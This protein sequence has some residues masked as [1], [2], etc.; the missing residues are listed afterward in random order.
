MITPLDDLKVYLKI[1]SLVTDD[2]VFL[3]GLCETADAKI[4][5]F[6]GGSIEKTTKTFTF[7]NRYA[8]SEK[9]LPYQKVNSISLFSYSETAI[10]SLVTIDTTEYTLLENP[11]RLYLNNGYAENYRYVVVVD[12]G[13]LATEMPKDIIQAGI[14]IATVMYKESDYRQSGGDGRLGIKTISISAPSGNE[15][16]TYEDVWTKWKRELFKYSVI[17]IGVN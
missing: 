7:S 12:V 13:Y 9:V 3:Q 1:D 5:N 16:T 6:L 2:D 4:R 10:D 8:I 17:P 11:Y 14:E 15:N